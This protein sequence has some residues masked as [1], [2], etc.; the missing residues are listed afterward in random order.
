MSEKELPRSLVLVHV[1]A[2]VAGAGGGEPE[3]LDGEGQ[4]LVV[5]V[6]HQEAVVDGLLQAL[7]LVALGN[8]GAVGAGGRALLNAGG[9]KLNKKNKKCE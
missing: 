8:E 5:G 9:L 7:G 4:V 1:G 3:G 2:V 6:V